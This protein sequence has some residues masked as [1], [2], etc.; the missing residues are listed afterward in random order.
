[1]TPRKTQNHTHVNTSLARVDRRRRLFDDRYPA[2]IFETCKIN[3]T[4]LEVLL[5][6]GPHGER[7][8]GAI[9]Q[10]RAKRVQGE[11]TR[12]GCFGVCGGVGASCRANQVSGS[13]Y[14][15]MLPKNNRANSE[16][17]FGRC[18]RSNPRSTWRSAPAAPSAPPTS[19]SRASASRML[20]SRSR[21][22]PR[23]ST[24]EARPAQPKVAHVTSAVR[25]TD[26][27]LPSLL[28]HCKTLLWTPNGGHRSV[29]A[30]SNLWLSLDRAATM[31]PVRQREPQES[32]WGSAVRSARLAH[33]QEVAGSNPAPAT[34]FHRTAQR[35]TNNL[36]G[37]APRD[38]GSCPKTYA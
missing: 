32:S 7:R 10:M 5:R 12:T 29:G 34:N 36:T 9:G 37:A 30:A 14:R 2:P 8:L 20:A 13:C 23:S 4:Q 16:Q 35:P 33:N 21:S 27:E 38:P 19:T 28:G 22:M 31:A 1:M 17:L 24:H 6:D 3:L 26:G 25:E 11:R 15:Q 18:G